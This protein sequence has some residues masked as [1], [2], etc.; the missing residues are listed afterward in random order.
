[1]EEIE[2]HYQLFNARILFFVFLNCLWLILTNLLF[3]G[4]WTIISYLVFGIGLLAI[5][6]IIF[7]RLTNLFRRAGRIQLSENELVFKFVH[8]EKQIKTDTVTHVIYNTM[9]TMNV[10]FGVL[11]VELTEGKDLKIY[12]EDIN[13]ENKA[14]YSGIYQKIKKSEK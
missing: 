14:F 2:Y 7:P 9:T 3:A 10:T 5:D 12:F 13:N 11:I 4:N 8:N 1:M 6:F